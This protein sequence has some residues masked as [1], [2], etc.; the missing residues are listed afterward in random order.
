[1]S[2][3]VD[4]TTMQAQVRAARTEELRKTSGETTDVIQKIFDLDAMIIRTTDANLCE[5]E[6]I[7]DDKAMKLIAVLKVNAFSGKCGFRSAEDFIREYVM[8]CVDWRF[9][10]HQQVLFFQHVLT[11]AALLLYINNAF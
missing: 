3:N 6:N 7:T 8:R 10:I 5:V 4:V 9:T 11:E 1:M 2:G